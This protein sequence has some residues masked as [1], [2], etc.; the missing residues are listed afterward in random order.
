MGRRLRVENALSVQL[1]CHP[2]IVEDVKFLH[3]SDTS[4]V[5]QN[6]RPDIAHRHG[7]MH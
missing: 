1:C 6:A 4:R 2:A 7:G 3:H 5:S